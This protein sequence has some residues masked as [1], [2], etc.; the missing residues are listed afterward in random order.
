MIETGW[1]GA[2]ELVI[3]FQ[4]R[5]DS[6]KSG[7]EGTWR[8]KRLAEAAEKV[9]ALLPEIEGAEDYV[10]ALTTPAPTEAEKDR[11]LLEKYLA[12]YTGQN[13]MD[14]FIHKDLGGFLRRELDF[15]IKNEVMRLDDIES[16][17]ATRVETNLAKVKVLRRIGQ[18]LIGFLAQ[19]ENYQK[20]LWLKKIFVVDT[21]YCMTLDRIPRE[22]YPKIAANENQIEAWKHDKTRFDST[23]DWA[24][25]LAPAARS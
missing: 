8:K 3:Q 18:H 25:E 10:T 16:S 21:Q 15:Y 24:S 22:Y 12:Q 20:R 13:T 19:L 9:K 4:Y 1:N 5:A 23:S 14:Y 6:E 7:Q 17:D 2:P 11:T